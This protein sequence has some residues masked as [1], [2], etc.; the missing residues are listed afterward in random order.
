M[1]LT[2]HILPNISRSEGNQAMKLGQLI[3]YSVRNN[4][5]QKIMLKMR[6][7]DLFLFLRKVLYKVKVVKVNSHHLSF[8]IFWYTPTCTCSKN[9]RYYNVQTV[10]PEICSIL[11]FYKRVWNQLLH[12][13]LCIFFL[14]KIFHMLYSIN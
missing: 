11:I 2:I 4:F 1:L 9:K 6:Q 7:E 5:P 14:R 10:D 3:K 12:H 13:I 8:N